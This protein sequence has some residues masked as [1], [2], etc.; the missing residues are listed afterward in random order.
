MK[1]D[2]KKDRKAREEVFGFIINV[3]RIVYLISIIGTAIFVSI[4]IS[5]QRDAYIERLICAIG[6]GLFIYAVDGLF[7]H[8]MKALFL[9]DNKDVEEH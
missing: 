1:K 6:L 3:C 5:L 4:M 8:R 7:V 2:M 9:Y